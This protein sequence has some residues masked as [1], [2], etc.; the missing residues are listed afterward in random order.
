[1]NKVLGLTLS[2]DDIT[3]TNIQEFNS[4]L[5]IDKKHHQTNQEHEIT[6][7]NFEI[8]D[9]INDGVEFE[10]SIKIEE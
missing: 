9:L 2:Y 10:D 3:K 7:N 6:K 4:Q 1:M 8:L 5:A